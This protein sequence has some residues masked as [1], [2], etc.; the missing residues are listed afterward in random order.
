MTGVRGEHG[1]GDE[2]GGGEPRLQEGAEA[3]YRRIRSPRKGAGYSVRYRRNRQHLQEKEQE[4]SAVRR[5]LF[6]QIYR[7]IQG[8]M[9]VNKCNTRLKYPKRER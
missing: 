5:T 1:E 4:Q 2:H 6:L 7:F 8:E 9:N 3:Q